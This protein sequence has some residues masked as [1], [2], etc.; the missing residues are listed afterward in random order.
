MVK[1][2]QPKL[3]LKIVCKDTFVLDKITVDNTFCYKIVS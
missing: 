2:I 3:M 1:E